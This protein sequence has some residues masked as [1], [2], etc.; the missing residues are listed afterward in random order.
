[1]FYKSFRTLGRGVTAAV[2]AVGIATPAL[3]DDGVEA[4]SD[5]FYDLLNEMMAGTPVADR[6]APL[7][8]DAE[9]V[10]AMH[11]IGGRDTGLEGLLPP[12]DGVA[13]L[14]TGGDIRLD[15][16]TIAV[17]GDTAIETGWER[18][19]VILAGEEIVLEYRVTNV[20]VRTQDGWRMV[21]HHTDLSEPIID[22]LA[23]L[24]G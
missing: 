24:E 2:L 16:Q 1:M 9:G 5:A 7:W 11:P 6:L 3:A 23:R 22:L 8:L 15:D 13:S 10:T 20:Y 19:R 12:Y 4:V 21:H 18:G 17:F 14:A